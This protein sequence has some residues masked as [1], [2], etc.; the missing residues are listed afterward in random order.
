M[1]KDRD[2]SIAKDQ[3][4]SEARSNFDPNLFEH[5]KLGVWDLYIMRTRLL[6]YLPT[7]RKIEEYTQIWKDIP[8][9]RKT[10][11]DMSTVALPHLSSYLVV[12][13]AKSLVPALRLW[14]VCLVFLF[15]ESERSLRLS[16]LSGQV[17]GI[18]SIYIP[19][20]PRP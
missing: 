8:Y 18:V 6:P 14:L 4:D 2:S 1:E 3:T 10:L 16:R 11:R 5:I 17:L 15:P 7:S 13:L 12:T 9:L 19:F 20:E